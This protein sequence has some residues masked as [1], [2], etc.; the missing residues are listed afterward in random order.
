MAAYWQKNVKSIKRFFYDIVVSRYG[1][2]KCTSVGN[3]QNEMSYV[4]MC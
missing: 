4:F 3:K 1:L 2:D